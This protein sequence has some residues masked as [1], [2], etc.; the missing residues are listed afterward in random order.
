VSAATASPRT[1]DTDRVTSLTTTI[2]IRLRQPARLRNLELLLLLMAIGLGLGA[3]ALVQL[4]AQGQFDPGLILLVG[5]LGV[6]G[7]IGHVVLRVAAPGADPFLLPIALLLNLI[8]IAEISRLDIADGRAGWGAFGVR[9]VVWS[10]MAMVVAFTLLAVLRN[11][12]V[13]QRYRYIAMF[14][15]LVLLL[16]PMLPM[17]EPVNGARVWIQLGSFSFQPGELAKIALA[18]FFAGYLVTARDSLSIMGRSILFLRFPRARD[19][20][21]ILIVWLAAMAVLV[22]QRDLGTAL[23]YFGVFV[24]MLYVATGRISWVVLGMGLFVGGALVAS[25]TLGYV[26]GRFDA[27]LDAFDNANYEALGGSYQ[28]VQGLFGFADGGMIGTSRWRRATT[29][30]PHSARSWGSSACSPSSASTCCSSPAASASASPGRTT[31]AACSAWA[32][33]S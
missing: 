2:R 23:L 17:F 32:S 11:H 3:L 12:R 7:I 10:A 28:L 22:F 26:N 20:G 6:L 15:G 4:G 8:G 30:S 24:V 13:L 1:G 27:W 31:S 33:R 25:Q 5:S 9:Q 16:L 29:S 21:P 18:V 14:T 19:L